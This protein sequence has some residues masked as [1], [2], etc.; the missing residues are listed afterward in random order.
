LRFVRA[1]T[2]LAVA[3][4]VA[5]LLLACGQ[6]S[7][8]APALGFPS[9][10]LPITS[11][12]R[13]LSG[14][15]VPRWPIEEEGAAPGRIEVTRIGRQRMQGWGASVVTD[16]P[17]DPLVNP[18]GLSRAQLGDVDRRIFVDAGIDLVRVFGTGYGYYKL[19]EA[20]PAR[21]DDRRFAFMRRVKRYGVRFMYTGADAPKS[22]K[23]GKTLAPR[24]E[25]AYARYVAGYLRFARDAMGVPFDYAAVANEPDNTKSLLVLSPPQT[26]V[27][28]GALAA[29]LRRQGLATK[30]VLGDTTG[31]GTACPYAN[32]QL[33]RPDLVRAAAAFATHPY[34][35]TAGQS[36]AVAELAGEAGVPVWQTEF[37]TGCAECG[38]DPSMHGAIKWARKIAG[39]LT[40]AQASAW[41]AFRPVADI[42][43]GPG[44]ALIVRDR[45]N[46]QRPYYTTKRFDVFRQYSTAAPT[47]SQ[48]IVVRNGV[49]G[50]LTVAFRK[51][52]R[53]SIVLTNPS[54]APKRAAFDLGDRS[55]VLAGRRTDA[56]QGFAPIPP[57]NYSGKPVPL[58]L[59]PESVTTYELETAA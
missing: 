46:K 3:V 6:P 59:P 13:A 4:V 55:G 54:T 5:A 10:Q 40:K 43:H 56:R 41:F 8:S 24:R 16:T 53:L 45:S 11:K 28:Y 42:T 34:R 36:R 57:V 32:W 12:T 33:R 14:C 18:A 39:A 20:Q 44:D 1:P 9:D 25:A 22:Q 27:V 35:G 7:A 15:P 30:L 37:G 23:R 21:A 51:G 2:V 38:D 26:N 19:I 47:G 31:W 52:G 58:V 50:T 29:Q 49:K 17:V 48:R